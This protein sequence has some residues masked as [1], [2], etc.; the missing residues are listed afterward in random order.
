MAAKDAISASLELA[1]GE[2]LL[3]PW[4]TEDA[5]ALMAAVQESLATVGRWLPWCHAGYD[6][7]A[8]RDWIEHCRKGWADGE[9]YAFPAFERE[10]GILLGAAG[11]NQRNRAHRSA[12]LGYWTR[13]SRQGCGVATR[14]ARQVARFGFDRLGLIRIEIVALPENRASRRTAEKLGA[15]F[16][17]IARQRLWVDGHPRDAAV[18]ALTPDDL[19]G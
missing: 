3:R 9:H 2:R 6:L 13:Q 16:E 17:G 18:Y 11:L 14:S 10:T 19:A 4:R 12:N 15:H 5:S 8:A 1:D 7:V